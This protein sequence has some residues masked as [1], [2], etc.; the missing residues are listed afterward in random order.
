MHNVNYASRQPNTTSA[1]SS[2]TAA[3]AA[4]VV[5]T[6]PSAAPTTSGQS[7]GQSPSSPCPFCYQVPCVITQAPSWLRESATPS[8][9]NAAKRYRLYKRFWTLL[10]QT[11]T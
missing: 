4:V 7:S 11:M 6:Q 9:S 8:L 5:G 2:G 1:Q 3:A 10:G